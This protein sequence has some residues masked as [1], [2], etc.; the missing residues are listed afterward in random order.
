MNYTLRR[1]FPGENRPDDYVIRLDG[2]D[3]GRVY[4]ST[5]VG[6]VR[7]NWTIHII[8]G[9]RR[10]EGVPISGLVASLDHA[11][12]EFRASFEKMAAAQ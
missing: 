3:I 1:V 9:L 12:Q 6:E 10:I 2:R 4:K 5:F 8:D 11:K 7:W